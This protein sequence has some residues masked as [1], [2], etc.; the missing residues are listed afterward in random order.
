MPIQNKKAFTLVELI[1]VITILAILWTIA[2][3]SLQWYSASARDSTRTTDLSL[4]KKSF[5]IYHINEW[6]YPDT[7]DWEEVTYS[8]AKIWTQWTFWKTTYRS[9]KRLSNIPL[10]PLTKEKYV[11]SITSNKQEYQLAAISEAGENVAINNGLNTYANKESVMLKVVWNYNGSILTVN[12][13]SIYYA[14]AVPSLITSTWWTLEYIIENWYLAFNWSK[15]L[16]YQYANNWYKKIWETW[17]LNLVNSNKLVVYELDSNSWENYDYEEER[18]KLVENLQKAY[19]GTVISTTYT[20]KNIVNTTKV[21]WLWEDIINN[22][23]W[24]SMKMA[25]I[26]MKKDPIKISW[27]DSNGR[28]YQDGTYAKTC[29]D[30][31]NSKKPYKYEWSIWNWYYIIRPNTSSNFK[32]YCDMDTNGGG[33][34]LIWRW[35][36]DWAWNN[37]WKDVS[38][39]INGVWTVNAFGPSYYSSSRIDAILWKSLK[40]L[41]DWVRLKRA[42]KIDWTEWQEVRWKF[43]SQNNWTW[44]F[45]SKN[46]TIGL[47]HTSI[48]WTSNLLG[49]TRDNT[50]WSSNNN[51]NRIFTRARGSHKSKKWFSYWSDVSIWSNDSLNFL[52]E[53]TNEGHAIPY[54]EVYIRK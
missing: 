4:I 6:G 41:E 52:W 43:T 11:Y 38:N 24:Y 15:N 8:W 22:Q 20:I 37:S 35:R 54:T 3:I 36:E 10:D 48:D 46:P 39:V 19:T 13:W 49:N 23:L 28:K 42:K 25:F 1:V 2:F 31:K 32:V 18:T 5:E 9:V 29:N 50:K 30:Y 53:N 44:I 45:D 17:G 16:P 12:T 51:Y 34:T 27:N 47:S 21:A 40:D 33:W 14:L 26:D 7:T